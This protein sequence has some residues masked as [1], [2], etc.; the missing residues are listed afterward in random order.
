MV[1]SGIVFFMFFTFCILKSVILHISIYMVDTF[2]YYILPK[3]RHFDELNF[4]FISQRFIWK[5]LHVCV[6]ECVCSG[7]GMVWANVNIA[8]FALTLVEYYGHFDDTLG[9]FTIDILGGLWCEAAAAGIMCIPSRTHLMCY[10]HSYVHRLC[11]HQR[12]T[13]WYD[14]YYI[15][16][17][18]ASVCAVTSHI[19]LTLPS[20][21]LNVQHN[22]GT[23]YSVVDWLIHVE[24]YNHNV[25][26]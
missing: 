13:D 16:Y 5:L 3:Y 7:V 1:S 12:V 15:T 11:C 20:L 21:M 10:C 19:T 25:I 4:R 18:I 24:V 9:R 17:N 14:L 22:S 26:L 2:K 8:T 23:W 6:Y